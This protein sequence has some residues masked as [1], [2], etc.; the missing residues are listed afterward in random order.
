MNADLIT[1]VVC[2]WNEKNTIV[3]NA[4]LGEATLGRVPSHHR[5]DHLLVRG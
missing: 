3:E 4:N 5:N 1:G 2:K